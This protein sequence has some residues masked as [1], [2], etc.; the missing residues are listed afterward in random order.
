MSVS[1]APAVLVVA[2]ACSTPPP[3]ARELATPVPPRPA[4]C[5]EVATQAAVQPALDDPAVTAVCLAPGRYIGP[6]WLRRDVTLWGPREAV[7]TSPAGTAVELAGRGAELLGLTLDGTGGRFDRLDAAARITASDTRIEGVAIENAVF[8]LIANQAA[9]VTIAGNRIHGSRDPA[10]GLRGDTIRL[11]EVTDSR[12]H[13]NDVEDGRDFVVWYSRRNEI[14]G[15]RLA[16]TR[17]G[18]HF[19]YSHDN[20]VAENE[21]LAGV[22]GVFVMYSRNIRLERN[23][24]ADAHGAAGMAIGLKDAGNIDVVDNRLIHNTL[25]VYIDT[26][27]MQLGDHLEIARNVFR[28]NEHAVVF[29]STGHR[30]GIHDNDLADN[31]HQL[32]VDGGGDA[33]DVDWRGNYFDDYAGYDL[34]GDERGDVPYE[35]RSLSNELT[36]KYPNL[37]FLRGT[38]AL[39]L[40]DAAAHLDPLYQPKP[41]LVDPAPA[42]APRWPLEHAPR[43]QLASHLAGRTP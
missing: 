23:L 1:R 36:A 40:V 14:T 3:V 19:M 17:Y 42:M 26:T 12:I 34:D 39:A 15:N 13:G 22:V 31:Q 35:L 8:G 10:T 11:W 32:R 43:P 28:L 37:D 2:W 4:G 5:R 38:P 29:H 24:I 7:I 27:P 41:L 9:R 21:L 6:F 20:L 30:V 16:R 18:L 25:A 33:L